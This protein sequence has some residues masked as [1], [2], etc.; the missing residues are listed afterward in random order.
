M[1]FI[2]KSIKKG[3]KI[4]ATSRRTTTINIDTNLRKAIKIVA[5]KNNRSMNAHMMH[6]LQND[7]EVAA[8]LKD[9]LNG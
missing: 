5:T 8:A 6:I 3:I 9:S 7:A 1:Q 2:G 4:M